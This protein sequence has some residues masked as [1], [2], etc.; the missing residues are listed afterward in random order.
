MAQNGEK[1]AKKR[2]KTIEKAAINGSQRD[3]LEVLRNRL[4]AAIDNCES[5]R[6]TAALAR[7]LMDV[8]DELNALQ[9]EGDVF[10]PVEE[11]RELYGN[12]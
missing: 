3:V 8:M 5:G 1:T 10:D 6:D 4:A 11:M 9:D 12:G 2:F 7:R